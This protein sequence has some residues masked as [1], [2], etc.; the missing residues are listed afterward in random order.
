MEEYCYGEISVKP[1]GNR[2]FGYDPIFKYNGISF[3]N[4]SSQEKDKVSHRGK[5]LRA[6]QKALSDYMEENN[7]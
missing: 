2:G 1:E 3:G 4:L 6:F 5:A 7:A